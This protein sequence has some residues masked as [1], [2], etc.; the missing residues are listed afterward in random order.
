MSAEPVR[1]GLVGTGYLGKA[2]AVG[3]LEA[4]VIFGPELGP[5][6]LE[7]V[8]ASTPERADAAARALGFRRAA[9]NWQELVADPAVDV[10]IVNTPNHLHEPVA[11][12]ALRAGKHVHCEKPLAPDA[13]AARRMA[14]A[15]ARARGFTLVGFNYRQNPALWLAREIVAG[16]EIGE[17][18][19]VR[20]THSEDYMAD[21]SIPWHWRFSREEAGHGALADV[22]S[23]ILAIVTWLVGEIGWVCGSLRTVIKERP[24]APGSAERRVV[25]NDDEARFLFRTRA[26]VEGTIE[27]SRIAHG[28]KL[29]LSFE[30]TGTRGSLVFD[31]ERMNE[32]QL[33]EASGRVDRRGFRRLLMA[34][35]HPLYGSFNTGPGHGLGFNDQK[36]VEAWLMLR[37]IRGGPAPS[38]DFAEALHVSRVLDAVAR[39]H[40]EGRWVEVVPEPPLA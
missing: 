14:E 22:G 26:G 7:A 6:V 37:A 28:R 39:S 9:R 30:I 20:A 13:E 40:T 19:S 17:V 34:P 11:V 5:V 2:F 1:V 31:Q 33:F 4:P 36:V 21:P 8:A 23:H 15:A 32:L 27:A 18:V 24:V 10:V 16:G 29:Y 35:Q 25:E 38:P 3:Y 12:A